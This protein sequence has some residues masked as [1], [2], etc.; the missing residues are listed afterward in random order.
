MVPALRTRLLR[1]SGHTVRR[2]LVI[3]TECLGRPPWR[4]LWATIFRALHPALTKNLEA[5]PGCWSQWYLDDGYLV[6][7]RDVLHDLLPQLESE[8]AKLGLALNRS[9]CNVLVPA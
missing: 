7:P 1:P 4:P 5:V 3:G 8:S 6:G 9:K 2:R